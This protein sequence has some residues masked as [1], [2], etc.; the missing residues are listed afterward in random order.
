MYEYSTSS[1]LLFSGLDH[2]QEKAGFWATAS[3]HMNI[4]PVGPELR[5]SQMFPHK[6][7]R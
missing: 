3:G 5:V 2:L 1:I 6:E 4:T 7:S